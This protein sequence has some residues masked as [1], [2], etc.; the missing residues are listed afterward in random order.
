[1]QSP[2]VIRTALEW[3]LCL[4]L[5]PAALMSLGWLVAGVTFGSNLWRPDRLFAI[6][7][8]FAGV[9]FPAFVAWALARSLKAQSLGA[10]ARWTVAVWGFGVFLLLD[11]Y[12]TRWGW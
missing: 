8:W 11:V 4:L 9:L 6:A 5:I 1:M 2:T 12:V 10:T 3:S 7:I